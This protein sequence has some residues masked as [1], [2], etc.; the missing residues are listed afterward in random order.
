MK[1]AVEA[2]TGNIIFAQNITAPVGHRFCGTKAHCVRRQ[3]N[4]SLVDGV[5]EQL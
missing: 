4:T 5:I 3:T 1:G 2:V